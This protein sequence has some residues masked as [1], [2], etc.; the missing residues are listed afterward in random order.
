[1]KL[2]KKI[3]VLVLTLSLGVTLF[4]C[5]KG[6]DNSIQTKKA[7]ALDNLNTSIVSITEA[8]DSI[9]DIDNTNLTINQISP[10]LTGTGNND[11]STN[12]NYTENSSLN[13]Y[14]NNTYLTRMQNA[15]NTNTN[16]LGKTSGLTSRK[17]SLKQNTNKTKYLLSLISANNVNLTDIEKEAI[18]SYSK[19]L[20]LSADNIKSVSKDLNTSNI[21]SSNLTAENLDITNANYADLLAKVELINTNILNA[22]TALTSINSILMKADNGNLSTLMSN[23]VNDINGQTNNVTNTGIAQNQLYN[24]SFKHRRGLRNRRSTLPAPTTETTD[25]IANQGTEITPAIAT[26]PVTTAP[27]TTTPGTRTVVNYNARTNDNL[28]SPAGSDRSVV[29]NGRENRNEIAPIPSRSQFRNIQ[30]A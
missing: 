14:N 22:E 21:N 23:L 25:N 17:Q 26:N 18:D 28:L 5:A 1:M 29:I 24:N 30:T 15:Y 10:N 13:S 16:V 4:A 11:Y 19:V 8:T 9:T 2:L 7:D 20:R 6:S 12:S 27:E 3:L